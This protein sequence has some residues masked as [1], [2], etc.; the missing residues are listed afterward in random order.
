MCGACVA[1]SDGFSPRNFKYALPGARCVL[2]G[3]SIVGAKA[4]FSIPREIQSSMLAHP[5]HGSLIMCCV[6]NYSSAKYLYDVNS[7]RYN[8]VLQHNHIETKRHEIL[9]KHSPGT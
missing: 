5:H 7:E 3:V 4:V 1:W 6:S 9:L 2:R 8:S